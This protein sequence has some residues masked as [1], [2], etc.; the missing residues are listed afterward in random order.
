[1]IILSNSVILSAQ[2]SFPCSDASGK[3]TV[4]L[5][6]PNAQDGDDGSID[7]VCLYRFVTEANSSL[8]AVIFTYTGTASASPLSV[9]HKITPVDVPGV[10]NVKAP[11]GSLDISF[12]ITSLTGT[13]LCMIRNV[14]MPVEL[15][16]FKAKST[17]E[18]VQLIWKTASEIDNLGF[19]VERSGN[20][21][22]WKNM[23]FVRGQLTTLTT[24]QY[25]YIDESPLNG[26]SYYRLKQ[27][28]VNGQFKYSDIVAIDHLEKGKYLS[29]FPNPAQKE[30]RFTLPEAITDHII[31]VVIID[32]MGK[33]VNQVSMTNDNAIDIDHLADGMY[34][35]IIHLDHQIF[36]E[37]FIK[38]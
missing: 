33:T 9:T 25:E 37:H 8:S 12:E 35:I 31:E 20:V 30:I 36:F 7:G 6:N 11:C 2:Q 10:F 29:L 4:V 27:M 38:R 16:E 17:I 28:D 19:E 22:D 15:L 14:L 24:H 26:L 34:T 32:A 13:P 23:V 3:Y 21:K 1:M 18:G 5:V